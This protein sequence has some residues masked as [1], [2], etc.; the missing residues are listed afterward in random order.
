M[1]R[2]FWSKSQLRLVQ[3]KNL[4]KNTNGSYWD[5]PNKKK[6]GRARAIFIVLLANTSG[7]QYQKSTADILQIWLCSYLK[8][9]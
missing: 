4:Q 9:I 6:T 2:A 3:M 5:A 8:S 1:K 7:K